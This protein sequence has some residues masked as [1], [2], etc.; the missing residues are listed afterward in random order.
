LV[1]NGTPPSRQNLVL[2]KQ[3]KSGDPVMDLTD[4]EI[5]SAAAL[6]GDVNAASSFDCSTE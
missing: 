2:T 6:R 4:I 5:S 1:E 3:H